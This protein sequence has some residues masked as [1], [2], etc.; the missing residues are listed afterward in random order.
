MY[1]LSLLDRYRI[2]NQDDVVLT[3]LNG[4]EFLQTNKNFPSEREFL[5]FPYGKVKVRTTKIV[6]L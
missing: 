5:E 4:L 2:I 3:R 1:K 6:V